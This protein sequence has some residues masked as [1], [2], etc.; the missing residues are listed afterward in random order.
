MVDCAWVSN[1]VVTAVE[2]EELNCGCAAQ[3]TWCAAAVG[4]K[5]PVVIAD[6]CTVAIWGVA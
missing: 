6:R 4:W 1:G 2:V 3:C 5:V